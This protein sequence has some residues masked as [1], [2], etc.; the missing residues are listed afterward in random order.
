M[1]GT[2]SEGRTSGSSA[3]AINSFGVIVGSCQSVFDETDVRGF[4]YFNGTMYDLNTLVNSSG[5][6]L[7]SLQQM[8]L[9]MQVRS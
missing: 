2:T 8:E 4:V 1:P 5:A 7:R 3:N 6:A 9:T